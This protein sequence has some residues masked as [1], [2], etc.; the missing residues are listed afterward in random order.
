MPVD[1]V[2]H[3]LAEIGTRLGREAIGRVRAGLVHPA[4]VAARSN[5][6]PPAS[7]SMPVIGST[8]VGD[9][10]REPIPSALRR[11][12]RYA[13]PRSR[14]T[15]R[16]RAGRGLRSRRCPHRRFPRRSRRSRSKRVPGTA[17]AREVA[18]TMRNARP[19]ARIRIGARGLKRNAR[20]RSPNVVAT[21]CARSAR[22]PAARGKPH[23]L[24]VRQASP[25]AA[26][27]PAAA[28]RSAAQHC[29]APLRISSRY[30][31]SLS[32]V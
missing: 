10:R 14:R 22:D 28:T 9:A 19:P 23:G 8:E 29:H 3:V 16:A 18:R 26:A 6:G 27:A 17:V 11:A 32:S 25:R 5:A 30:R 31:H 1:R 24:P 15:R 2:V 13:P 12:R 21:R 7:P 20:T 4:R